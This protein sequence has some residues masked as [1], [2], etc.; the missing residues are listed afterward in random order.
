MHVLWQINLVNVFLIKPKIHLYYVIFIKYLWVSKIS[1]VST[2]LKSTEKSCFFILLIVKSFEILR[3]RRALLFIS[4]SF[5]L[6]CYILNISANKKLL[7][8]LYCRLTSRFPDFL[9]LIKYFA[10]VLNVV[11]SNTCVRPSPIMKIYFTLLPICRD[12][13]ISAPKIMTS[14]PK[15]PSVNRNSEREPNSMS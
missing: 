14:F 15:L 3:K 8:S 13:F 12:E 5:A 10:S 1:L 4:E 9:K 2:E 7:L 11:S 6:N